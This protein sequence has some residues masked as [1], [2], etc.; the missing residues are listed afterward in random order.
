MFG[1]RGR[2]CC[3]ELVVFLPEGGHLFR[4]V[5][6]VV[7]RLVHLTECDIELLGDVF[8]LVSLSDGHGYLENRD[9]TPLQPG[10]STHH[11]GRFDD[12]HYERGGRLDGKEPNCSPIHSIPH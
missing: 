1:L 6:E 8:R 10:L 9:S 4:I 7:Q 5:V 3:L 12:G 11:V 2:E